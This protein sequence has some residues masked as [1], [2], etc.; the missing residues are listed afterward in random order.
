MNATAISV[1]VPVLDEEHE[2]VAGLTRMRALGPAEIVV[3]DGGSTDRTVELARPLA[4][5]VVVARRGRG[6]QLNVAARAA[7]HDL[8]MF[9]HVDTELPP[10]A[11]DAARAALARPGVV[12]GAFQVAIR[13]PRRRYRVIEWGANL[14]ARVTRLQWGDQ[15]VFTSRAVFAELDGFPE[16]AILEDVAFARRLARRGRVALLPQQVRNS[17]RRW[18]LEGLVYATVRNWVITLLYAAGVPAARLAR[19]YPAVR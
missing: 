5:R 15:A 18:E 12:G 11:F 16:D 2:V 8:L 3:A 4:D 9:V 19:W 14:R 6:A 13:D 7:S 10:D 1:L 17:P